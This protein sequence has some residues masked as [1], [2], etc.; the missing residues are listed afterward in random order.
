MEELRRDMREISRTVRVRLGAPAG[1][2]VSRPFAYVVFDGRGL[3]A[4]PHAPGRRLRVDWRCL[5]GEPVTGAFAHVCALAD[6]RASMPFDDAGGAACA[7]P[8]ASPGG[9]RC[10]E[11]R[12]SASARSRSTGSLCAGAVTVARDPNRFDDD[13]FARLFPGTLVQTD[14]FSEVR[15]PAGPA[16]ERLT[17]VRRGRR[18]L[19]PRCA[20]HELIGNRRR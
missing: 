9:Y 10:W 3:S 18:S 20:A 1:V 13:P 2:T 12:W 19:P 14:L 6:R 16:I 17:R 8:R 5:D 11:T 4:D 15:P 7:A